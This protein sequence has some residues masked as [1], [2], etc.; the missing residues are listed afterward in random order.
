MLIPT[1]LLIQVAQATASPSFRQHTTCRS[2]VSAGFGWS[3]AKNR[4]GG[5]TNKNCGEAGAAFIANQ[6]LAGAVSQI[7][8]SEAVVTD[9]ASICADDAPFGFC[10]A[11]LGR[12]NDESIRAQCCSTCYR[13]TAKQC[14]YGYEPTCFAP[15]GNVNVTEHIHSCIPYD[16]QYF[17]D[18]YD[19]G[20]VKTY[21]DDWQSYC[22]SPPQFGVSY[23]RCSKATRRSLYNYGIFYHE[24]LKHPEGKYKWMS[25]IRYDIDRGGYWQPDWSK[26]PSQGPQQMCEARGLWLNFTEGQLY[27]ILQDKYP[28]DISAHCQPKWTPSNTNGARYTS[29]SWGKSLSR[30]E[31]MPLEGDRSRGRN[32]V[33]S[34]KLPQSSAKTSERAV[35]HSRPV[36]VVETEN[37]N[38]YHQYCT[39]VMPS[40]LRQTFQRRCP[41]AILQPLP[42]NFPAHR[43]KIAQCMPL[44]LCR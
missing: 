11:L 12:C 27:Y 35:R 28:F 31:A 18:Q 19:Y 25:S 10:Q 26:E 37:Y 3:S 24:D 8:Q 1:V 13:A 4:C 42:F 32:V 21:R 36:L 40:P 17:Y 30:M 38:I 34:T 20:L 23:I 5:F 6:G 2:C 9:T 43:G 7:Q 16:R 15:P 22:D 29:Y 33:C 39:W 41:I 14:V 44:S